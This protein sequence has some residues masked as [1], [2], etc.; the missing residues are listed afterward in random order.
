MNQIGICHLFE[1][2][3]SA[4]L[5]STFILVLNSKIIPKKLG[6]F[7]KQLTCSMHQYWG[8]YSFD[9]HF[10]IAVGQNLY[11]FKKLKRLFPE[12]SFFYLSE[13]RIFS[14]KEFVKLML[15]PIIKISPRCFLNK[16]IYTT[17]VCLETERLIEI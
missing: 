1:N 6:L 9:Y 4:N 10:C 8:T 5:L 13:C 3:K 2:L 11:Y 12:V 7:F 15:S 17:H 16:R 14:F